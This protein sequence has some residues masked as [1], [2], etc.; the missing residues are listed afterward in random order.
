MFPHKNIHKETWISPDLRTKTQ[1]DHVLI[2]NRRK[3]SITDVRSF[4]GADIGSDHYLLIVQFKERISM[5]KIN[6]SQSKKINTD[7]LKYSQINIQSMSK[8]LK[9]RLIREQKTFPI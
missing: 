6:N 1:I 7:E 4:R 5:V 3:S 2:N 8:I 9:K